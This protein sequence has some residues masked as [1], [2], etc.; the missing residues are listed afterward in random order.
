M[1]PCIFI[2][3]LLGIGQ[4]H[5]HNIA[6]S[7][8]LQLTTKYREIENNTAE[9]PRSKRRPQC[10]SELESNEQG[11]DQHPAKNRKKARA[12]AS[13]AT[14]RHQTAAHHDA[15]GRCCATA[16]SPEHC[17]VLFGGIAGNNRRIRFACLR[18][19]LFRVV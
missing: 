12:A 1:H 8:P 16:K 10:D 11:I 5:F 9:K 14:L 4:T 6:F 3:R 7:L 17:V 15:A 13:L 2:I 19:S 18:D